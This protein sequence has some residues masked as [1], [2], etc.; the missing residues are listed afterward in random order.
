[1]IYGRTEISQNY[2]LLGWQILFIRKLCVFVKLF[3]GM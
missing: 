2:K 1:M 3:S